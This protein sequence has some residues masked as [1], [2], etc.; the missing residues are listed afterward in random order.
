MELNRDGTQLAVSFSDGSLQIFHIQDAAKN[1]ILMEPS[2]FTHFEG[3]FH[4]VFLAWSA[5]TGKDGGDSLLVIVDTEELYLP[6]NSRLRT[7]YHVQADETGIFVT[8][9]NTV[10]EF[11]MDAFQKRE[12]AHTDK[13]ISAFHKNGEFTILA[14]NNQRFAIFDQA[15]RETEADFTLTD[16]ACDYVDLAGKTAVAASRTTPE[17]RLLR[18]RDHGDSEIFAYDPSYPHTELR[19]SADGQTFM[20]YQFDRFRVCSADGAILCDMMIPDA[21]TGNV[22]DQ[23][24]RRENG[25]SWLEVTYRDGLIRR[26]SARDGGLLSE[27][28][29]PT[30]DPSMDEEFL[31]DRYRIYAPL[32]GMPVAYDRESGAVARELS[33]DAMLADAKQAGDYIVADYFPY[34]TSSKRYAMILDPSLETVAIMPGF[35][36][37]LDGELYYD[38]FAGHVRKAPL[39]SREEL[40]ALAD[41][42]PFWVNY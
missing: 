24:F 20:L 39:Y 14:T 37:I 27:E 7:P 11:D 36:D 30:P 18:L 21:G 16:F 17:V 29:G 38:D 10:T 25:E 12:L 6:I 22:Y 4:G 1:L 23:Q 35:C 34:D 40:I 19:R 2:D 42:M 13:D 31:T 15:A 28:R 26:Y 32:H 5:Y 8:S 9:E 3:G 33:P 41:F